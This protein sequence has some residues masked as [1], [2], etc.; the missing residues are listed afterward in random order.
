MKQPNVKMIGLSIIVGFSIFIGMTVYLL[1]DRFFGGSDLFVMYF[2]ESV[3]GLNV[4]APVVFE[5][6]VVGKVSNVLLYT[7][8]ESLSFNIPVFIRINP[9]HGDFFGIDE[10]AYNRQRQINSLIDEGLRAKLAMQ[11]ILTGQLMVELSMLP[12]SKSILKGYDDGVDEAIEIPTVLSTAGSLSRGLE[13]YPFEETFETLTRIVDNLDK[14]LPPLMQDI[15]TLAGSM[16][17]VVSYN[18]KNVSSLL[19]NV[20][21]TVIEVGY[22]AKS[23]NELADYIDRHPE[24]LLFGKKDKE[25]EKE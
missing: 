12:N 8:N 23:V 20:N 14:N 5:G 19:E 3:K 18:S 21:R 6:V 2:D 17:Q 16:E 25:R 11:S 4:G 24:S 10:S 15:S 22:A 1:K 7:D 13:N 9:E